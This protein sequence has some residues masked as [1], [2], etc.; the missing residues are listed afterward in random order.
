M[1][2]G[3][4][5]DRKTEQINETA[6]ELERVKS[7]LENCLHP[8]SLSDEVNEFFRELAALKGKSVQD[9]IQETMTGAQK[10]LE[11]V[12]IEIAFKNDLPTDIDKYA[13]KLDKVAQGIECC[14]D[15]LSQ[16]SRDFFIHLADAFT[17]LA[18]S[19]LQGI[20][21]LWTRFKLRSPFRFEKYKSALLFIPKA[22]D[23]TMT[24]RQSKSAEKLDKKAEFLL[25][26]AKESSLLPDM[27]SISADNIENQRNSNLE[28]ENFSGKTSLVSDDKFKA[29]AYSMDALI[30]GFYCWFGPLKVRI[31]GSEAEENYPGI[32]HSF[33]G[34]GLVLPG[35]QIYTTYQGSYDPR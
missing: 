17:K 26:Q 30:P 2:N 22:V 16:E 1:L 4:E 29:I 12:E 19:K 18:T 23:R 15:I 20:R 14:W 27:K 34:V 25:R 13:E 32:I 24:L 7:F 28:L 21:G 6:L 31:G 3:I 5:L 9:T 33:A 10:Y 8:N 35:Y 11:A